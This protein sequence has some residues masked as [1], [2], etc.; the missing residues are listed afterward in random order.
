MIINPAKHEIVHTDKIN[1]KEIPL[2]YID[3]EENVYN[4]DIKIEEDFLVKEKE[5]IMPYQEFKYSDPF[6]FD[7]SNRLL[8]NIDLKKAGELYRYEPEGMSRFTPQS[9]KTKVTIKKRETFY[10]NKMYN[11]LIAVSENDTL[12]SFS[13]KMITFFGDASRR[14]LCPSNIIVNSGSMLPES[15]ISNDIANSDFIIIESPNGMV[16]K[17]ADK[18]AIIDVDGLLDNHTNIWLAIDNF[19]D[20]YISED[21][22]EERS[23]M[24]LEHDPM[25]YS[26]NTYSISSNKRY[27]FDTY[28]E[29][30]FYSKK[31]YTY[32]LFHP[33]VLIL[34]KKNKGYIIITPKQIFDNVESNSKFIYE[35]LMYVYLKSYE[36]T[37]WENS[38]ITESPVDYLMMNAGTY[39]QNHKKINLASM[40]KK[41]N[42]TGNEYDIANIEIDSDNVIFANMADLCLKYVKIGE[43]TDVPKKEGQVSY[44]TSSGQVI[45]YDEEE[46]WQV[47]NPI[48]I[49]SSSDYNIVSIT[50]FPFANSYYRIYTTEKNTIT[51]EDNRLEYA[52]CASVTVPGIQSKISLVPLELY[53]KEEDGIL[54]ARVKVNITQQTKIYDTRVKGGGIP[55]KEENDYEMMDIGNPKGRPYRIGSSLIITLPKKAKPFHD[56]IKKEVEKHIAA[57]DYPIFLYKDN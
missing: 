52:V 11:L 26:N 6:L 17:I 43:N 53:D 41:K 44:L 24:H 4:A 39:K 50:V 1:L 21:C 30:S 3:T 35:I 47:K 57:G 5:R 23:V 22:T 28:K 51:I 49:T 16:S 33:S 19:E 9:F 42:I 27:M 8:T 31:K 37:Y 13:R 10:N 25:L 55:L 18:F 32:D 34:E 7:S 14:G 40:L 2:A 56:H 54:I 29:H 38:W 15:L 20:M 12:L 46:I 45:N 48:T 36:D